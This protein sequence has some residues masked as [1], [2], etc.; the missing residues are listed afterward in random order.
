MSLTIWCNAKFSD[1]DTKL[2][3]DG[4]KGHKLHF[5]ETASASVLSAGKPDPALASA[6]IAF[7]QPDPGQCLAASK[8]RW[9]EVTSAGYTRYDTPEFREGF[10][11]RDAVFSNVSQVFADPCA[12]HLLAQMLALGRRLLPSYKD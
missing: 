3:V 2:L 11:R 12:Q 10:K 6:D 7:G 5:S 1:A 8:L 9:V 4:T